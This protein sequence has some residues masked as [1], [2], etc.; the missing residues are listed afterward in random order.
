MIP[1]HQ[2]YTWNKR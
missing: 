2:I 1:L